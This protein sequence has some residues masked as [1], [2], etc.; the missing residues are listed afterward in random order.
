MKKAKTS[1]VLLGYK[2][3][4]SYYFKIWQVVCRIRKLSNY[5]AYK[6]FI[7]L[8]KKH[9]HGSQEWLKKVILP[10]KAFRIWL[11]YNNF[12]ELHK[13]HLFSLGKRYLPN[14]A[15]LFLKRNLPTLFPSVILPVDSTI[16]LNWSK[17][18]E[19]RKD[20]SLDIINFGVIAYNYRLQRPQHIARELTLLGHRVFYIENEFIFSPH[21]TQPQISVSQIDG[22]LYT[23]KLA[24]SKNYFIY[25]D[26]PSEK[27]K[28]I[29]VASLK[30]L[31]RQARVLNPIA[32]I[33]HPFWASIAEELG[34]P[35]I[36]DVMDLH[37]GFKETST[38]NLANEKILLAKSDLILASSDY[39]SHKFAKY[40]SKIIPLKNA[41]EYSHFAT[42]SHKSTLAPK[43]IGHLPT[44]II[45]YYGALADWLNIDLIEGL[46]RDIPRASI[47]LIGL[48]NNPRLKTLAT[49][50]PNIH[51]LGE[52]PYIELPKYLAYFDVCL[53][54]FKLNKLI[55]ATNPV[56]I[57]EYFASGKPVVSTSI[58]ELL[59]YKKMIY[60]TDDVIGFTRA[61]K[62]A[63]AERSSSLKRDRQQV[64]KLNTWTH[65]ALTL[66]KS[67][68]AM[69]PKVSVVI[70]VY[71]HADLSKISIDSVLERSK[72]PNLELILVDNNSDAET[73]KM[74][75][76][77]RDIPNIKLIFNS[78]NYGFAKGNNIGMKLASGEYIILLNND[79]RVTPGWIERLVYHARHN[80]SVGL[81]GPVTNSIGNESKIEI[82][83]DWD[84][85]KEIEEK[86]ADYI[87]QHWGETLKLR[88]IAAF[89]WLKPSSVYK[90]LGGLDERFGRGLFEDDDYCVRVKKAG[91]TIL[92]AEDS[93]VHHYGGAST[94]WGS[95]EFQ[96]LFN[97]NKAK[98][99]EK[100]G[101]KWIPH[102]NR[103]SL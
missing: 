46:A 72:Y 53:I 2:F 50:Y 99:E 19:S 33:D 24:S 73:L 26:E 5:N 58:P 29:I 1:Q 45:G 98:F 64:A 59:P 81:V 80:S 3:T 44:P 34:M 41:G 30:L 40:K 8:N 14:K 96:L 70:L 20:Q 18:L 93:F 88:N 28:K 103:K 76:N 100:W 42:A 27:D 49:K 10:S 62:K 74:L 63:L 7:F 15:K 48:D 6:L 31:L 16:S 97:T 56:K 82:E 66:E 101:T 85:A 11:K 9:R 43:D 55:Q 89:A 92:C 75:Q 47:V 51:L 4:R 68:L 54:P 25:Q 87:Y 17:W 69:Y 67:L 52:K 21:P 102:K 84:N 61:V 60:L 36:Y 78:E 22:N 38:Y 79:V 23:V 57:Y 83:Y 71:N 32:K 86:S 37:S 94:N 91:L 13:K 35:I 77:Y 65:R 39:L 95:P 12:V 90:K